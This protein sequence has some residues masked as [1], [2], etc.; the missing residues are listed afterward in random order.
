MNTFYYL[1]M[2]LCRSLT[3]CVLRWEVNEL[4]WLAQGKALLGFLSYKLKTCN[5]SSA[6]NSKPPF[7]RRCYFYLQ[8]TSSHGYS[9]LGTWQNFLLKMNVVSLL[10][11][12]KQLTVFV[13]NGKIRAFKP[14]LEFW[15]AYIHPLELDSFSI[16]KSFLMRLVI[17][18][19]WHLGILL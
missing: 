3:F 11:Q 9:D 8:I 10:L 6:C 18:H 15:K 19:L 14:K 2:L 4:Y 5:F 7:S 17:W 16:L 12:R 13:A 1:C